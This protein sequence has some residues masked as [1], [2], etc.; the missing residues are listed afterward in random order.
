MN[1]NPQAPVL[2]PYGSGTLADLLPSVA[3]HLGAGGKDVL[4]LPNSSRYA[5][6]LVDGLGWEQLRQYGAETP[7]LCSLAELGTTITS[8]VP[9]TTGTA[10]ASLGTGLPPGGHGIAGFSFRFGT[11]KLNA[12]QYPKNVSGYDVQPQL[13]AFERMSQAGVTCYSVTQEQF[14]GSGLTTS[15]LRGA[16]FLGTSKNPPLARQVELAAEAAEV[17]KLSLVYVYESRLDHAGHRHGVG[18][19][20]WL[21]AL[22]LADGLAQGL[23]QQL[24]DDVILIVTGDHGMV[25]VPPG[26]RVLIEDHPELLDGVDMLAGEARLRHVY[27]LEPEKAARAWRRVLGARA[28][29]ATREQARELGWFGELNPRLADRFGDVIA[30]ANEDWALL[31]SKM[32]REHKLVGMHGSLTAAEMRVPLLVGHFA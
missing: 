13:T 1:H 18:S 31:T 15:A 2:P 28:Q 27:T 4:G 3:A 9:S 19:A 17:G 25:N 24:P 21:A 7:F 22:R 8:T 12:L 23:F 26:R 20:E 10:L 29:V 16:S 32:P 5:V 6:L 14:L 30:A 11:K